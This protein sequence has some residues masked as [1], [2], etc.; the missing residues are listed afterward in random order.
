MDL[1]P[2]HDVGIWLLQTTAGAAIGA[3]AT[4]VAEHL[5]KT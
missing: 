3:G 5:K 4:L 2:F 1:W